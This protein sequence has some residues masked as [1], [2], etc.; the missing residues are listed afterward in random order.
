MKKAIICYV[1]GK[2]KKY[3]DSYAVKVTDYKTEKE[4]VMGGSSGNVAKVYSNGIFVENK[5]RVCRTCVKRMGYKVKT[6]AKKT[7][8]SVALK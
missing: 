7:A 1:C 5:V 6:P 4:V 2:P 3:S 8:P